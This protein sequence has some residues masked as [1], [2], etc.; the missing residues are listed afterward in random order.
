[1]E[2]N[3]SKITLFV[4]FFFFLVVLV[5]LVVVWLLFDFDAF[6]SLSL[7]L[8]TTIHFSSLTHT[9]LCLL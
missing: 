5:V 1:M 7:S 8:R 6:L 4:S 9:T 2:K 3:A